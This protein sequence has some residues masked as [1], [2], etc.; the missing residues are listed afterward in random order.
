M[1]ASPI[2][3]IF[4]KP[5]FWVNKSK[6]EKIS[7]NKSTKVAGE[8]KSA[9]LV[10]PT[11]SANKT[12][13]S[14]KLSA[15]ELGSCFRRDTMGGGNTF[16]S[17]CSTFSCSIRK[18]FCTRLR[19]VTSRKIARVI[20]AFPSTIL[21]FTPPSTEIFSPCLVMKSASTRSIFSPHITRPNISMQCSWQSGCIMSHTVRFGTSAQLYPKVFFQALFTYKNRPS[22]ATDWI[23]SLAFS[24]K[25]RYRSSLSLSAA[26]ACLAR[27]ISLAIP[28]NPVIFPSSSRSAVTDSRTGKR[29]PSL[30]I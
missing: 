21:Q 19:S 13:A 1:Y 7:F 26:S 15:I 25:S 8:I 6:L 29:L 23:K 11:I 14:G 18:A 4:S 9:I 22:G 24:N 27:V 2:V 3:L 28:K 30:R 16:S 10:K 17:N 12:V 5:Y 20:T